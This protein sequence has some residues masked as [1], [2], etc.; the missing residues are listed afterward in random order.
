MELHWIDFKQPRTQSELFGV[1]LDFIKQNF[2]KLLLSLVLIA[3]PLLILA[4]IC[5]TYF[6][7]S[8][9][10]N[11]DSVFPALFLTYGSLTFY[12]FVIMFVTY[13]YVNLY[14]ERGPGAVDVPDVFTF[15]RKNAFLFL[16]VEIVSL[17]IILGGMLFC[18]FPGIYLGIPIS[19][20]FMVSVR[21]KLP[22]SPALSRCFALVKGNWWNVFFFYFLLGICQGFI[23]L[24]FYVPGIIINFTATFH[25]LKTNAVVTE[26]SPWAILTGLLISI[27]YMVYALGYVGVA[28]QY[29]SLVEQK[30]A[31]GL[32][33]KLDSLL[34]NK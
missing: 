4:N 32:L 13:A 20:L 22:L 11:S 8:L 34:D 12:Q 7:R 30:N 19:F 18:F 29:H 17:F 14:L 25:Q 3:G 27:G 24:I 6:L 16:R 28:F 10:G 1:T 15:M 2:R 23:M 21:E 9:A 26:L 31:T 5:T 33:E